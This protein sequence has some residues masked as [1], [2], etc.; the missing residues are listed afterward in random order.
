MERVLQEINAK[1][2][3]MCQTRID[4]FNSIKCDISKNI[5]ESENLHK[6]WNRAFF[7]RDHENYMVILHKVGCVTKST[8]FIRETNQND[9]GNLET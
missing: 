7:Y 2:R 1:Y 4:I 9:M 6:R 8:V 5:H 3:L